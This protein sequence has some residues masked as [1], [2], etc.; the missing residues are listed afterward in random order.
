MSEREHRFTPRV[1][2]FLVDC[3]VLRGVADVCSLACDLAAASDILD[4]FSCK[5]LLTDDC[6]RDVVGFYVPLV[7]LGVRSLRA[8][9]ALSDARMVAYWVCET[10]D[11]LAELYRG[12]RMRRAPSAL[13]EGGAGCS[14][15]CVRLLEGV[16][17]RFR[18]W[19]S[20]PP[21]VCGGQLLMYTPAMLADMN[22]CAS[23]D[24]LCELAPTMLA[25][26]GGSVLSRV[27]GTG[28]LDELPSARVGL[29]AAARRIGRGDDLSYD[30]LVAATARAFPDAATY[31]DMFGVCRSLDAMPT[32][33]ACPR[34]CELLLGYLEGAAV[35]V[36]VIAATEHGNAALCDSAARVRE[37]AL[38]LRGVLCK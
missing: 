38:R 12:G 18:G 7:A 32:L 27:Q 35:A 6:A 15:M 3:S 22:V 13:F 10:A 28:V 34:E 26:C 20:V 33:R 9:L 30:A 29:L 5:T 1:R 37:L 25:A 21:A 2:A 19:A 11:H 23:V 24:V 17:Q 4:C 31:A 14:S 8:P 16:A 36:E